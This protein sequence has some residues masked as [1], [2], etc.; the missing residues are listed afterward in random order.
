MPLQRDEANL[1]NGLLTPSSFSTMP[2][3]RPRTAPSLISSFASCR[4]FF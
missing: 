4:F 3:A 1:L 2:H